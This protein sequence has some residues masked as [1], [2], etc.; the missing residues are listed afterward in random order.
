[1]KKKDKAGMS[2]ELG[3]LGELDD[4]FLVPLHCRDFR[5]GGGFQTAPEFISEAARTS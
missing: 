3:F 1:M 4:A 5:S 2:S